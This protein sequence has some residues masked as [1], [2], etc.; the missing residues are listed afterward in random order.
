MRARRRRESGRGLLCSW[1]IV[2][3]GKGREMEDD[4]DD[5]EE[6]E[7]KEEEEEGAP[8]V[9]ERID[10]ILSAFVFVFVF[11]FEFVLISSSDKKS[12][13][14]ASISEDSNTCCESGDR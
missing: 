14:E 12:E 11:E 10:S 4:D 1:F 9:M 8:L 2:Q 7:E 13:E 6:E 5:E 3:G